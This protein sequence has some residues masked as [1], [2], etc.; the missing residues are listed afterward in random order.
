[1]S[2]KVLLVDDDKMVLFL[3]KIL[4]EGSKLPP[5]PYTFKNGKEV[6]SFLQEEANQ[7]HQYFIL[8]DLNMPE[9]NGWEFLSNLQGQEEIN[10]RVF[11]CIVTS[12][13]NYEDRERAMQFPQVIEYVEKPLNYA[14]CNSL[15]DKMFEK[16]GNK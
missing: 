3:H 9:M 16:L 12:S 6:F 10:Q 4:V 7:Q 13:I 14:I 15:N 11:V 1:M 2:Y 5:Q 8:L